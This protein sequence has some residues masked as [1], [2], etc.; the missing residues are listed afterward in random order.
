MRM[1]THSILLFSFLFFCNSLFG[2]DP[3]LEILKKMPQPFSTAYHCDDMVQVVNG[4]RKVGKEQAIRTLEID[5]RENASDDKKVLLICRLLF[6]N[7][8]GWPPPRLG[9]AIPDVGTNGMAKFPIFPWAISQRVPFLLVTGYRLGGRGESAS[10][11][12]DLCRGFPLVSDD[13]A[14]KNYELAAHAL[15]GSEEFKRIYNS[16]NDRFEMEKVI[17]NQAGATGS[18]Q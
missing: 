3:N 11:C 10:K 18:T 12:L 9:M 5:L 17:L 7:P 8:A 14:D 1:I 2:Q 4:L 13:L 6:Q 15:I 16:D